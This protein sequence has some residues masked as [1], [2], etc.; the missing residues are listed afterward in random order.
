MQYKMN[1]SSPVGVLTI[2]TDGTHIT[3]LWFDNQSDYERKLND[4]VVA[5]EQPIFQQV[6][7]WLDHYF[8]GDNPTIDFPFETN[9]HRISRASVGDFNY[10]SFR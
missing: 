10:N 1:Y 6:R 4:K 7:T 9:W 5:Q 8:Q 2:T 3:G